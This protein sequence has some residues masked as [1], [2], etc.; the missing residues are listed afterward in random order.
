MAWQ[1]QGTRLA[2][3]LVY[4]AIRAW[5]KSA[6][7]SMASRIIRM[8]VNSAAY[9]RPICVGGQLSE[10]TTPNRQALF[11]LWQQRLR[12]VLDIISGTHEASYFLASACSSAMRVSSTR[13]LISS[14]RNT[15]RRWNATVCVLMNS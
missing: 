10:L 12:Q 5:S 2:A 13:D 15:W 9:N 8:L 3:W 4:G 14:L 6:G 7:W 1:D 11:S